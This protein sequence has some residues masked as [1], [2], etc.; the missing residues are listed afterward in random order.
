MNAI[1]YSTGVP[2]AGDTV[3][4]QIIALGIKRYIYTATPVLGAGAF[5]SK[6]NAKLGTQPITADSHYLYTGAIRLSAEYAKNKHIANKLLFS[7]ARNYGT[8]MMQYGIVISNHS[9]DTLYVICV[10]DFE[11]G[12]KKLPVYALTHGARITI[13]KTLIDFND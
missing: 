8:M 12:A 9:F 2:V 1:F 13:P 6:V 4:S 5:E 7:Q 10:A 11:A 3:G